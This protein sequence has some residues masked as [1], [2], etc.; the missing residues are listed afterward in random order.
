MVFKI[1]LRQCEIDAP[2]ML[3]SQRE[4]GYSRWY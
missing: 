3:I 2:T 4:L 1:F